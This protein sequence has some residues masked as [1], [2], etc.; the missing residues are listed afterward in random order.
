LIKVRICGIIC[1]INFSIKEGIML[2][3]H[4][5]VA[6]QFARRFVDSEKRYKERPFDERARYEAVLTQVLMQQWG[7][8][9][10][11]RF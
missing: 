2:Y 5:P 4:H 3:A 8:P 6:E 11:K 10:P 9:I 1:F 7:M